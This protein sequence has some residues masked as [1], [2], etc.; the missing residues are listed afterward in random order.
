MAAQWQQFLDVSFE[1]VMLCGDVGTFTSHSQ[2]DSATRRHSKS[3]PCELEFLHQWSATPQPDYLSRIFAPCGE[4]GLGLECPVIM[5]HG[6]HEG[7]AHLAQLLTDDLPEEPIPV[8]DLPTVDSAG[9]IH[10]LPSGWKCA[11]M[12]DLIIGGI[13]GIEPEQRTARYHDL[14][15]IDEAAVIHLAESAPFDLLIT[16]Q[17]PATT[18]GSHGSPSLDYLV[19]SECARFWFHGH[20][21]PDFDIRT[22]G[23]NNKTTIVPLGDVAFPRKGSRTNDPGENAWCRLQIGNPAAIQRE[24]PEFWRRLRKNLWK[25]LA[26]GQLVCPLLALKKRSQKNEI[27]HLDIIP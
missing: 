22:C 12:S 23:P 16:H 24:R 11:T 18:Q 20:A 13:G 10:Y 3:N 14:A 9:F 17:G 25:K 5:V 27:V 6:N 8:S 15:Y 2:L 19:H 21:T 26:N 1:A 4:G 7:F